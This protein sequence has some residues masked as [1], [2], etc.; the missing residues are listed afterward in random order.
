MGFPN[1][2]RFLTE[3]PTMSTTTKE[4]EFADKPVTLFKDKF[5]TIEITPPKRPNEKSKPANS[6]PRPR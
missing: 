2:R 1:E 5:Q 6:R 4:V 3:D